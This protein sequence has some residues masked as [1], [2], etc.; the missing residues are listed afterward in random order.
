MQRIQPDL[1]E[2]AVEN[3]AEGLH[4][5]AYLLQR[6]DGNILFYNTGNSGEIAQ[7]AELGGVARQ[8]LS[9]EDELGDTLALIAERYGAELGGHVHEQR[10]FIRYRHPTILFH[11]R[12]THLNNVEVIPTPGHTTGST[13]FYVPSHDGKRYLFTGDTLWL[14]QGHT[15]KTAFFPGSSDL[16]AYLESLDILGGLS[17]DM[18][19][20]SATDGHGGVLDV[21]PERWAQ[22]LAGARTQL[23]AKK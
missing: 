21:T 11:T 7:L 17:P 13:C 5:H 2:T 6:D 16:D 3:P 4:T 12:E 15:L 14:S 18:V 9:H 22:Q 8:Y 23:L 1:W 20:T 19:I 10:A